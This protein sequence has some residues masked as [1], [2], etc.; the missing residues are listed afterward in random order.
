VGPISHFDGHDAPGLIDKLVPGVAAVIDDILG[1]FEDPIGEPVVAHE[2]PDVL[3]W[4][5]LGRLGRQE[6]DGDVG[7]QIELVGS[8]PACL[9]HQDDGVGVGCDCLGQLG[10]LQAHRRGVAEGQYQSRRLALGRTDRP[11]DVGRLGALIVWSR[12]P[13]A[14]KSPTPSDLILLADPGLVAEPDLYAL[15]RRLA[16]RDLRQAG[17]ELFLK[18]AS[19]SGFW[20]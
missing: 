5:Q 11:E 9:I 20:A 14:A 17:G 7:G 18:A 10:E 12:R 3:G 8:V 16:A 19:A 15:A 4:V 6:Q 2:L 1:G 13:R